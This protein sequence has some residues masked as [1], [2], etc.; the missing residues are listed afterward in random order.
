MAITYFD[1]YKKFRNNGSVKTVPGIKLFPKTTDKQLVYR[2]GKTRL[3]ILSQEY[4]NSPFYGFL[5]LL[6]NPQFG[7][8]EFNINDGEIIRIPFP[9]QSTLEQYNFEVEKHIRLYG[10]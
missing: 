1:R 5:I 2:K 4:Y 9:L 3:D 7:G 8:L 10:E 6:A